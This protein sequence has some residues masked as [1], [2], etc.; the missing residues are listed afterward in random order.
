MY[1]QETNYLIGT[2]LLAAVALEFAGLVIKLGPSG[3]DSDGAGGFLLWMFHMLVTTILL[4][5]ALTALG[6]D[7]ENNTA[8]MGAVIFGNV[9]KEL[10]VLFIMIGREGPPRRPGWVRALGDL[11]ILFFYC[12]GYT[13]GWQTVAWAGN[14]NMNLL[15]ASYSLPLMITYTVCSLLIFFMLYAPLRLAYVYSG[16][17]ATGRDRVVSA[18]S[19]VLTAVLALSPL[20]D[21]YTSLEGALKNPGSADKLFLNGRKLESLSPAIGGLPDLRVLHLGFNRLTD[22]PPETARLKHLEWLDLSGNALEKV[23][24][25]LFCLKNL[26]YL[27]LHYNRLRTLPPEI[28]RMRSLRSLNLRFNRIRDLPPELGELAHLEELNLAYC[29]LRTLPAPVLRLTGLRRLILRNNPLKEAPP[30]LAEL[31][32]LKEID[33]RGTGIS[34][35]RIK[36]LLPR[37][38]FLTN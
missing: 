29:S 34:R 13:A 16:E 11:F 1:R 4:M 5:A 26:A 18:V 17:N 35:D 24:E 30:G 22:L 28:G 9:I 32:Q 36:A 21:G 15:A 33:I 8:V 23:P 37:V 12:V 14:P 6:L 31:K 25:A 7:F 38:R 20:F 3:K 2:A 27:D 10:A 19:L